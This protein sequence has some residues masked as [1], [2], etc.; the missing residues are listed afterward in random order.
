MF[1]CE[2]VSILLCQLTLTFYISGLLPGK[3]VQTNLQQVDETHAVFFLGNPAEI[4]HV[5]VF[6]LGDSKLSLS[7]FLVILCFVYL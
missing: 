6:L 7:A 3:P 5:C 4:N 2:L 1:G